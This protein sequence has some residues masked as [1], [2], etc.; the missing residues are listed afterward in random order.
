MPLSLLNDILNT[1]KERE[2]VTLHLPE[3]RSAAVLV[4][5]T[6]EE[7]P[8]ILL[9]VRSLDLPS[10]QGQI[11]FPGGKIEA[12]ET[13]IEAALREAWEEVGLDPSQVTVHGMWD[14]TFTPQGF[15]VTPVIA[16][17][18]AD[19]P[20]TLTSEVAEIL[21]VPVADLMQ[22]SPQTLEREF[23]GRTH[24]I[25]TYPWNGH[26]IWGMTGR[27]IHGVLHP[28]LHPREY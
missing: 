25:Y 27:I 19:Y 21:L 2:R 5:F 26:R 11:S 3:Y 12:G 8:R 4:G 24:L 16:T 15:H 23:K 13:I 10:H 6:A 20:F 14:D 7:N 18:P 28:E 9:T 1:L 22:L 17:L